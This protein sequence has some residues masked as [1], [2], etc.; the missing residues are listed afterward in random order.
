[1]APFRRARAHD[2]S[3]RMLIDSPD[4]RVTRLLPA[5]AEAA[6]TTAR[7][8]STGLPGDLLSQSAR[9]LQILALLYSFT[10][11]MSAFGGNM[12]SASARAQMLAEYAYWIPDLAPIP[13]GLA[14]G[15]HCQ[16]TRV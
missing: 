3:I 13:A 12:L 8:H 7:Q 6:T 16:L 10:F 1:M 11:F 4:Q 9:R 2:A 14:V 15:R 5:V